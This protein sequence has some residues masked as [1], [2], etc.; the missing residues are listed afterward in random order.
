LLIYTQIDVAYVAVEVVSDG[1]GGGPF[2]YGWY[3]LVITYAT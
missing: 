2:R 3:W 1:H